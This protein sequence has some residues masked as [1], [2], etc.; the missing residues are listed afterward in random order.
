ME[1]AGSSTGGHGRLSSRSGDAGCSSSGLP[2][3]GPR[4]R[5]PPGPQSPHGPGR[6]RP[7]RRRRDHAPGG[8]EV[9]P[10]RPTGGMTATDTTVLLV[11]DD[12]LV[13]GFLAD[14]LI[15]DGYG[16]VGA[17]TLREGLRLLEAGAL[18]VA[19]VDVGLPDGSGLELVA[20]VRATAG[21]ASH[22]DPALPV[23]V[24]S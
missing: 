1:T 23:L 18:D 12:P 7:P 10:D 6:A 9:S 14:N 15:A 3:P 21:P 24:L 20:R 11:E 5:R 17:D 8:G 19:I 4:T 22:V 13:R 16:V 2:D